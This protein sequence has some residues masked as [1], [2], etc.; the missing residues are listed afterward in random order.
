MKN[1]LKFVGRDMLKNRLQ[2]ALM[3]LLIAATSFIFFF[4][5]YASDGM[6]AEYKRFAET[7]RQE[8]FAFRPNMAV[9]INKDQQRQIIE[10][11][12]ISNRELEQLGFENLLQTYKLKLT[13]EET[14]A[15]SRLS[16]EYQFQYEE[17][18][19][20]E[21][22]EEGVLYRWIGDFGKRTV[23]Q[24]YVAEGRLPANNREI[25]ITSNA[26]GARILKL[27]DELTIGGQAYEIAG[28]VILPDQIRQ[29]TA[30]GER[31]FHV[32]A[33]AEQYAMT[34]GDE[35]HYYSG[36]FQDGAQH[37]DVVRKMTEDARF[38]FFLPIQD[39]PEAAELIRGIT[40]N[41]GMSTIFLI[42]LTLLCTGVFLIFLNRRLRL[43]QKAWGCLIAMGYPRARLINVYVL[44]NV[45]LCVIGVV[46][47]L[48]AAYFAADLL[49]QQFQSQ[50]VLPSFPKAL[51]ID[52]L[53]MGV[54]AIVICFNAAAYW[55]LYRFM[56]DDAVTMLL[57]RQKNEHV[58]FLTRWVSRLTVGLPFIQRVKLQMS[59]RSIKM[60]VLL[61]I[62]VCLSSILFIMGI[63][64]NQSSTNAVERRLNGIH[65]QYDL[66]YAEAGLA[67]RNEQRND[68]YLLKD[69]RLFWNG[70]SGKREGAK[71]NVLAFDGDGKWLAL[72]DRNGKEINSKLKEGA[73]V[74]S[75]KAELF[76]LQ[77]GASVQVLIGDKVIT[78]PIAAFCSNGDPAAI[79][80]DK[81]Q[82]ANALG[83]SPD[84]YNGTFANSSEPDPQLGGSFKLITTESMRKEMTEQA[85]SS[86]L[87][88]VLNQM[89]GC[90]IAVIMIWLITLITV[91]ENKR[92]MALLH[93]LGYTQREI[94]SMLLNVYTVIVV[95]AYILFTPLALFVVNYILKMVSL[96]T[97]DFIPL[98]YTSYTFTLVLAIILIIYNAVLFIARR[99]YS[100]ASYT[101]PTG[102]T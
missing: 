98:V 3:L 89:L 22:K 28:R 2:V 75:S 57:A 102:R 60:I 31:P 100:R 56:N 12:S 40:S 99:F 79:Y 85:S 48:V 35:S 95:V 71:V 10:R 20:K 82:L 88:A 17:V 19:Y 58:N 9:V 68:Y 7:Q 6:S 27:G 30:D 49:I 4:I 37:E 86:Q 92:N 11:A 61:G 41:S 18:K 1:V 21:T 64:L 16:S 78:I 32:I 14:D 26:A 76:G 33:S 42:T 97:N 62:T 80:M 81:S 23:N 52:S 15:V 5:R 54:L 29:Y 77:A 83:I 67:Q 90:V 36:R 84:I 70:S 46:L 44:N 73:I 96:S 69:K 65:Y 13:D 66:R 34:G 24:M 93:M 53:L 91:E 39:N 8:H 25:A 38:A 63:S 51:G 50:F 55:M 43:Q 101:V 94:G 74:H 45:L 72:A 87:S 47:G 59:A